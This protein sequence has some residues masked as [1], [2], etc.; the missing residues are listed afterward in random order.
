ME[1]NEKDN[2]P[3]GQDEKNE[4]ER[5]QE[6]RLEGQEEFG[7]EDDAQADELMTEESE[8]ATGSSEGNE[9][10]ARKQSFLPWALFAA[11]LIAIAVLLFNGNTGLGGADATVNGEKI[12]KERLYQEL[13]GQGGEP[14]LDYLISDMLIQQQARKKN[15]VIT[16]EEINKELEEIKAQFPTEEQFNAALEQNNT[17]IDRLKDSIRTNL[18]ANKLYESQ[19][20]L[21][22]ASLQ[23]FFSTN[24]DRYDTT[25][26]IEISHILVD[27]KEE[28]EK[29]L[30]DLNA[31]ADFVE[32]A[33]AHSQDTQ[34]VEAGGSI[35]LYAK[36]E[37]LDP[38][39]EEAAFQLEK[40][41]ISSVVQSSFGFHIIKV[42]DK[43]AGV[44]ATYE[45]KKDQVREDMISDEMA[46]NG[47][48]WMEKMKQ[49]AKI[50][51]HI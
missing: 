51:K 35:G 10:T 9:G 24:K 8:E 2:L 11:S 19:M 33:K 23:E 22:E 48:A 31:G 6:G 17:S 39:F 36:G 28:A 46:Q 34:S 49:E 43:V 32:L 16:D 41:A 26:K 5:D 27:E 20:D 29:L 18:S 44:T 4:Q 15:I 13:V 25:D 1:R 12:S 21:T 40:G 37:G 7:P 14:A 47:A 42:T 50:E 45:E 3:E 30:A 38:A